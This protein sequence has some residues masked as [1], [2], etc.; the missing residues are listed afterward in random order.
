MNTKLKQHIEKYI[1]RREIGKLAY[2]KSEDGSQKSEDMMVYNFKPK[3]FKEAKNSRFCESKFRNEK[4]K[5][6]IKTIK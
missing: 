3:T 5:H 4:C 1:D 6:R 2:W